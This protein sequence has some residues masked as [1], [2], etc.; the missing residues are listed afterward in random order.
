MEIDYD[1]WV[2]YIEILVLV[3]QDWELLLVVVQFIEEQVLSWFIVFVVIMQFDIKNIFFERNKI[4]I[5][6]W[7]SEKMEMVNGYEVKVYG[8]FNVEFIIWIWIEYFLE[9]YK[10]K[11]KGCKMFLQFFL[12]IVEQYGGF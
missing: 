1:C 12:G 10:G 5:L 9:Q 2:V 8:V 7:C 4:G 3:G 6:G 11:V